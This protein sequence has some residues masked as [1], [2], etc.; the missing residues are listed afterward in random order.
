M[1]TTAC[2]LETDPIAALTEAVRLANVNLD[3]ERA[4]LVGL[5]TMA[6]QQA[7]VL[8]AQVARDSAER[9]LANARLEQDRKDAE[10]DRQRRLATI[11]S[12][13]AV[14]SAEI[15]TMQRELATLPEKLARAQHEHSN[16]LA[17]RA[18]I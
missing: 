6:Q 3:R 2:P 15:G 18:R 13:L 8:V 10:Q 7:V 16:L 14:K 9:A 4:R 17:E 11:D 1:S 12:A 5:D